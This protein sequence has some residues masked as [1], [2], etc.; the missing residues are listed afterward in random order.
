MYQGLGI[1]Y[2]DDDDEGDGGGVVG[3]GSTVAR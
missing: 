2:D 1:M 3:R